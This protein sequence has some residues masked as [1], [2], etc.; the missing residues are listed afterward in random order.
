MA[1]T[2][3]NTK[4]KE[5]A[6]GTYIPPMKGKNHTD[7]ANEK[8]RISHT[9]NITTDETKKKQSIAQRRPETLQANRERGALQKPSKGPTKPEILMGEM[10]ESIGV[11]FEAQYG[12]KEPPC[13]PDF[14][15]NPNICIFA[16]GDSVHANPNPYII[17]SRTSTS[18]PG[19][20][21]NQIIR[22]VSKS[23]KKP[24]F[25]RDVWER[26]EKIY[27]ELQKNGYIQQRKSALKT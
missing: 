21:A 7:T 14:F 27:N 8:N 10:L 5:V 22:N 11:K 2:L 25:A 3:S 19:Y 20:K 12:I 4:K 26:D 9:G 18:Q 23:R 24:L 16:D 6:E 15:I 1:K 13:R 17:P